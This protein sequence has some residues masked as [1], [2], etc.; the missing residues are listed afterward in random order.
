VGEH[1]GR[2]TPTSAEEATYDPDPEYRQHPPSTS[3]APGYGET[4]GQK[5]SKDDEDEDAEAP[6]EDSHRPGMEPPRMAELDPNAASPH[7]P[8]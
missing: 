8:R 3:G 5:P 2:P 7:T 1:E 6:D 4:G